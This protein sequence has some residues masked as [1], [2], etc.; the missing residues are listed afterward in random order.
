LYI[1]HLVSLGHSSRKLSKIH[2]ISFKQI[3]NW[4]HRFE[5]EG[6]DGLKDRKGRGRRSTISDEDMQ[7][8]K[9]IILREKPE[10]Y[11]FK[12]NRWTGPTVRKLI[13]DK[14]GVSYQDAQI[15][16]LLRKMGMRF[17][18]KKGLVEAN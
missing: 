12:S 11:G 5:N 9:T 6:I 14:Y 18:K 1:V 10:K 7:K 8:I 13:N 16:N 4:V 2:N 15:Y 17:K 3:T